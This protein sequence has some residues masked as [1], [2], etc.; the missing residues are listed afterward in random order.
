MGP[1]WFSTVAVIAGMKPGLGPRGRP[2]V[3]P[4]GGSVTA[5]DHACFFFEP[6]LSLF[7][8]MGGERTFEMADLALAQ[9]LSHDVLFDA[10]ATLVFGTR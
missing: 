3:R 9:D 10:S 4:R 7:R 6:D 5:S 8:H 2:K 1:S